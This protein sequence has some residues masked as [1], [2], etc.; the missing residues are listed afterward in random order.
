MHA[1]L[2][3]ATDTGAATE[4]TVPDTPVASDATDAPAPRV[5][6]D[7]LLVPLLGPATEL[8]DIA[9]CPSLWIC[10]RGVFAIDGPDGPF[11]LAGRQFLTL[12]GDYS[13]AML[14]GYTGLG[15]LLVLPPDVF[16]RATLALQPRLGLQRAPFALRSR[17]NRRMVDASFNALRN[18]AAWSPGWHAFQCSQLMH[19]ALA[20][21][22]EIGHWLQRAPGRTESQRRLALQKLMHARNR[23]L[24]CPFEE[25]DLDQ[26]AN[27]AEYSKSHFIKAFRDVFDDTPGALHVQAR[28][29]MAKQLIAQGALSLGEIAS[30]VGYGSRCAFS[31]SFKTH[32]GMNASVF[33]KARERPRRRVRVD[34]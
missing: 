5:L 19:D 26:L 20:A 32:V 18:G 1:T 22:P 24:N 10:L 23:I 29:A 28:I 2:D 17:A 27:A 16:L 14:P 8:P 30:G 13:A 15:L 3:L 12:P 21:Q 6:T 34:A 33:R 9:G 11:L 31:R 4:I 7:A 25:H